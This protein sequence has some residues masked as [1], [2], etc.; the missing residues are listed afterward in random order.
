MLLFVGQANTYICAMSDKCGVMRIT[1]AQA[2][3]ILEDYNLYEVPSSWYMLSYWGFDTKCAAEQ[4]RLIRIDDD[5]AKARLIRIDDD[6]A[7]ARD[8][9]LTFDLIKK[10]QT[11]EES[12]NPRLAESIA[13]AASLAQEEADTKAL[14]QQAREDGYG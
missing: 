11:A 12:T 14:I 10:L 8:L 1:D 7:K 13:L 2:K 9:Q 4:A 5:R 3:Q 6:L